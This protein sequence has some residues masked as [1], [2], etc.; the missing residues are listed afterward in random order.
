ME[1]YGGRIGSSP[2]DRDRFVKP[3]KSLEHVLFMDR[4]SCKL[5]SH[6]DGSLTLT[7]L[8]PCSHAPIH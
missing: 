5:K 6:N 2:V 1:V 4:P 8:A 3:Q 7:G